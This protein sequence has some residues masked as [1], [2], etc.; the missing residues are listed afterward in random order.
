[1]HL[2]VYWFYLNKF[3][4]YVWMGNTSFFFYIWG[5]KPYLLFA[6]HKVRIQLWLCFNP[7]YQNKCRILMKSL[8]HLD[9]L[10]FEES[11]I[12]TVFN[13]TAICGDH[14]SWGKQFTLLRRFIEV[15][16]VPNKHS[17]TCERYWYF[18]NAW[19]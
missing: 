8:M 9:F 17:M 3:D 5:I 15:I 12:W 1:M 2:I 4:F 6:I 7:L 16:R 10:S 18:S 19:G 13:S 11:Y 14:S